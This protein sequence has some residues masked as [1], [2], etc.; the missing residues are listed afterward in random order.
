MKAYPHR[1]RVGSS[2]SPEGEVL[3]SGIGLQPLPTQPPIEFDGPGNRWSPE[4]L[5]VGAVADCFVLSF[6]AVARAARLPWLQLRCEVD[7]VLERAGDVAY[8]T[9]FF[10]DAYLQVPQGCDPIQAER[11]LHRAEQICLVS[12]SLR[13]QRELRAH[14]EIAAAPRVDGSAARSE[15]H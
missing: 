5:L 8:F 15:H 9:R 6:R 4:T 14:V 2:A 11:A 13:G 12:N 7:G 1:Y 10:L 3:L